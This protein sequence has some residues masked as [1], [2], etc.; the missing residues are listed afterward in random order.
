MMTSAIDTQKASWISG[1]TP[2]IVVAAMLPLFNMVALPPDQWDQER[3]ENQLSEI[4]GELDHLEA[5]IGR[6]RYAVGGSLTQADGALLPMLQLTVEWLPIFRGPVLL[7]A[8][9]VRPNLAAYWRAIAD[10]P[11]CARLIDETRGALQS[12]MGQT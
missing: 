11:I 9:G 7:A 6:E 4:G 5:Y 3:I 12:A 2:R 8:G 10:D 1:A